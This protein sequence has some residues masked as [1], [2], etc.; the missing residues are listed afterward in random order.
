MGF[1]IGASYD[2]KQ[3]DTGAYRTCEVL[4][5]E[6]DSGTNWFWF[7]LC[8]RLCHLSLPHFADRNVKS[9]PLDILCHISLFLC[10]RLS[11]SLFVSVFVSLSLSLSVFVLIIANYFLY[12][13]HCGSGI[14]T[15]QSDFC[16]PWLSAL[17]SSSQKP[18]VTH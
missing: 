7:Y 12:G 9:I 11:L 5:N 2:T 14:R 18:F 17:Q 6:K 3:T 10:F 16:P 13:P 4:C 1:D 8:E 15:S